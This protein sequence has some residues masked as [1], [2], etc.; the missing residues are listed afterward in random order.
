MKPSKPI[1]IGIEFYKEIIDGGYYYIDKTL[2][3]RDLLSSGNKV[4]LFTRPRRFGKTLTQSMLCTFF[5][6]EILPDGTVMD[7][8]SYFHGKKIMDTGKNYLEHM[9]QYPVIFMSLK[10]A[11]QPDYETAYKSLYEQIYNE[12][13]R[14]R[15]ILKS[16]NI[17]EEDKKIYNYILCRNADRSAVSESIAFLSKCLK[18]YYKKKAI[19][20]IDEYDV[21]LENA[22]FNGFYD[23]M[24]NFIRPLFESALKTNPNLAFAVIT[25]C[26]RI[27]RESI[28][29]GLN[30]LKTV[31][32]LDNSYAEYFGFT[33]NEV[34]EMLS[35]YK[36][37]DIRESIKSWYNGYLFGNIDVYNP[38][39][40]IN[41][42]FDIIEDNTKFPKPYWSNT[43][44]NNIVRE[45]IDMADHNAKREVEEL[46]AGGV[47]EKPVHEDITYADIYKSQDNLWNF[48]FFTGY[49]KVTGR[50][51]E[52]DIIYL[53]LKIP[54]REIRYIYNNTIK[55]WFDT[56]IKTVDF[57]GLY[58]AIA[59][60]NTG[61]FE[62]L[63]KKYL[64]DSISY[65]DSAENFYHGF[66]LGLLS[67]MQ[68]YERL[69]NRESGNG[70]YD[71]LLKPYDE[72]QPAII[73][74]I[75]CV[76][77]F[78]EMENMCNKALKQIEDH[79]YDAGLLDEGYAVVMKYGVCFC[80][81]S[82]MI[83]IK[84]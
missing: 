23:Q 3:I 51:F 71:I 7:N 27:S 46:V 42:V 81:K 75:K 30:N 83:K 24:V 72:K 15:Y 12:F 59:N 2:L 32:V 44:S 53:D 84:K 49:L 57:S 8:S 77:K 65:L 31:S 69:S 37:Q 10:P 48:L 16:S 40:V 61:T 55:E 36:I 9:G 67:G 35:F 50:K 13:D 80:K 4:T 14:H 19:I 22:Y 21:P 41:Y 26:L 52:N 54:N 62:S 76:K 38:W 70:R 47:L 82:C 79:H 43:S 33:Q 56:K 60:G 34:D 78:N 25:G 20:L 73:I 58:N 74:E 5:E 29:T 64:R 39:S 45:L 68:D 11:K 18:K 6:K 28:F 1:P 17:A 63:L 66:L